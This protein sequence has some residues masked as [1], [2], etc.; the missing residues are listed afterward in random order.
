MHGRR[1][2]AAPV[3]ALAVVLSGCG[4][5]SA[6]DDVL[7]Q[8]GRMSEVVSA[9]RQNADDLVPGPRPP[10]DAPGLPPAGGVQQK[11]SPYTPAIEI[12]CETLVS[13][14]YSEEPAPDGLG[15][16]LE[17]FMGAVAA[18][19]AHVGLQQSMAD[20]RQTAA[21]AAAGQDVRPDLLALRQLYCPM[22]TGWIP[23]GAGGP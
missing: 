10:A 19:N 22:A 6:G 16:F 20:V 9:A 4:A 11:L 2:A 15:S 5:A 1:N 18:H 12:G 7:R 13:M 8:A 3:M 23:Q 21:R 14:A 17:A